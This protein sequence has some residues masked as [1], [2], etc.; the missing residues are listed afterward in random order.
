MFYND[1]IKLLRQLTGNKRMAKKINMLGRSFKQCMETVCPDKRMIR[2][3]MDIFDFLWPP[4]TTEGDDN[5]TSAIQAI[6]VLIFEVYGCPW[7]VAAI[8]FF[9]TSYALTRQAISKR[10]VGAL[11]EAIKRFV[12]YI[13]ENIVE[14][15]WQ[16]N[17][18]S[19]LLD[20]FQSH[21]SYEPTIIAQQSETSQVLGILES[22]TA[23]SLLPKCLVWN[24]THFF[25][26]QQSKTS[27]PSNT[28]EAAIIP[29]SLKWLK[30]IAPTVALGVTVMVASNFAQSHLESSNYKMTGKIVGAI[31]NATGGAIIGYKLG[32]YSGSAVGAVAGFAFW[33]VKQWW[34]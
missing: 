3:I 23:S 31:G 28:L 17:M 30:K 5:L 27:Q 26:E 15:F 34:F 13:S 18:P 7:L 1:I 12:K 33:A 32:S 25:E 21:P 19:S 24:D 6:A 14:I 9:D 8:T 29:S 2:T 4:Q 22:K 20:N 10:H 11:R 16:Q